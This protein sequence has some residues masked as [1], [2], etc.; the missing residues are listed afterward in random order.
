MIDFF[1]L[2]FLH[3]IFSSQEAEKYNLRYYLLKTIFFSVL[4]LTALGLH[5]CVQAFSSCRDWGRLSSCSA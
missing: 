4:F 5:F 1:F 2:I 3:N